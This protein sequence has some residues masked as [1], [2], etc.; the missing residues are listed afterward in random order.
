MIELATLTYGMV[1]SF[2]FSSLHANYKRQQKNPA[3]MVL[4]GYFLVGMTAAIAVGLLG[5]A[6]LSFFRAG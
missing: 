6:A 5:V 3:I 2:V 1:L 4:A